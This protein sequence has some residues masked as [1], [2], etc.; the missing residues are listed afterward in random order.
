GVE[1]I[2]LHP[3]HGVAAVRRRFRAVS[4]TPEIIG[5]RF[6]QRTIIVDDK[7]RTV[8]HG[9]PDSLVCL[10]IGTEHAEAVAARRVGLGSAETVGRCADR[11]GKSLTSDGVMP[12]GEKFSWVAGSLCLEGT[13]PYVMVAASQQSLCRLCCLP[14]TA[15]LIL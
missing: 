15:G 5:H 2:L 9:G 12:S 13:Q 6:Q 8:I 3:R 1:G 11:Q 4:Q 14:E 10:G 7:Q